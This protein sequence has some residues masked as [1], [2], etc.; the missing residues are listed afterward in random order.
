[1]TYPVDHVLE[2]ASTQLLMHLGALSGRDAQHALQPRQLRLV[3]VCREGQF[4]AGKKITEGT[5]PNHEWQRLHC[6]EPAQT[7]AY[8]QGYIKGRG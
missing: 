1:M 8:S 5:K 4:Q 3:L 2:D 7:A 6:S